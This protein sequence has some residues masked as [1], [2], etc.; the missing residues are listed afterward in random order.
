LP[1]VENS[2]SNFGFGLTFRAIIDSSITPK[3]EL[4]QPLGEV[5]NM[6]NERGTCCGL[7]VE[8]ERTLCVGGL[9]AVPRPLVMVSTQSIPI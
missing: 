7:V 5:T 8:R 6:A 4:I 3:Q 1:T 9:C 2:G